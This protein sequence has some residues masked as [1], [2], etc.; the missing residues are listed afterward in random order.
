MEIWKPVKEY[1]EFYE[2]SNL[3]NVRRKEGL[4]I[5]GKN[6]YILPEKELKQTL[7]SQKVNATYYCVHLSQYGKAKVKSVHR[8]VAEAFLPND[9]CLP[10]V[11]HKDGNK[12]NNKLENLEWCTSKQ[13]A[14]HAINVLKIKKN[15]SGLYLGRIVTTKTNLNISNGEKTF[16]NYKDIMTFVRASPKYSHC[17][18]KTIKTGV[19]CCCDLKTK[20]AFGYVWKYNNNPVSTISESG[21]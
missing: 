15:I 3:G 16:N 14:Q 17:S 6:R 13:N 10:Q 12:L 5:N 7:R 21:E 9:E 8:L 20:T 11:N 4:V 18:D 2:V 1:E 19:K